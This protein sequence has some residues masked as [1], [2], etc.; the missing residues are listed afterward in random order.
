MQGAVINWSVL[1]IMAVGFAVFW[2]FILTPTMRGKAGK[3]ED[4]YETEKIQVS[5][6][7]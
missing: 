5:Q 3:A 1:P 4:F 2:L 7:A 6:E